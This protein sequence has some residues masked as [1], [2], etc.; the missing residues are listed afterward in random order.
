MDGEPQPK[1]ANSAVPNLATAPESA[2]ASPPPSSAFGTTQ[3]AAEAPVPAAAA[4]PLWMPM[5]MLAAGAAIVLIVALQFRRGLRSA[6]RTKASQGWSDSRPSHAGS[7]ARSTPSPQS[8]LTAFM[9]NLS[10][11]LRERLFGSGV[12]P[13][14][15]VLTLTT[16]N[17]AN[18]F[19]P[20]PA[21]SSSP[22]PHTA[23]YAVAEI[24]QLHRDLIELA[25]RQAVEADL[26]ASRLEDL[27]AKA[28]ERIERSERIERVQRA[29]RAD[30]PPNPADQPH[31]MP[32]HSPHVKPYS[33][34]VQVISRAVTPVY[35]GQVPATAVAPPSQPT[36]TSQTT[37][38]VQPATADRS[39]EALQAQIC[40]LADAGHSPLEIAKRLG[41]HTGKVELIL[42]L[43]R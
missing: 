25:Q 15:T 16:N 12:A 41:Q 42:A 27:I 9:I 6:A 21:S 38:T 31:I 39:A 14:R 17:Q 23:P 29:D 43:R 4:I 34:E 26:R 7:A 32:S 40:Q 35:A 28:D 8:P 5:L 20:P 2:S 18:A 1:Q 30:R 10:A 37:P 36:A 3:S 22:A 19:N 11:S 24:R 13:S 33:P